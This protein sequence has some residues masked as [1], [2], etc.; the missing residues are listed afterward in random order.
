MTTVKNLFTIFKGTL[1][2]GKV[3]FFG[4]IRVVKA[5]FEGL[6]FG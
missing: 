6:I 5:F 2:L 3:H 1:T 4:R